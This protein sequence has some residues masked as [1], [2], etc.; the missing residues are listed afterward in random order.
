LRPCVDGMGPGEDGGRPPVLA[1]VKADRD[2]VGSGLRLVG[3][4]AWLAVAVCGCVHSLDEMT[5]RDFKFSQTF[6]RT[7]PIVVLRDSTDGDQR[8][9]AMRELKE[10]LANGGSQKDQDAVVEILT[11]SATKDKEALCRMA[12]IKA[13]A[14]FKDARAIGALIQADQGAERDF[15]RDMSTIIRQQ[16]L[17]ALGENRNA[18]AREWLIL[19]ARAGAKEES[20]VEKLQ[21]LDVRLT[22]IRSLGKYSQYES[23]ETL[24][25]LFETEKD[26]AVRDRAYQ[27]LQVATGKHLPADPKAWENLLHHSGQP[28]PAPQGTLAEDPAKNRA[29]LWWR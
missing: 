1:K 8:A 3:W 23:T 9:R 21:T 7:D 12:A 26:I 19:V 18:Q 4:L 16:A 2:T 22:A 28:S 5:A 15:N 17:A 10:P 6:T 27:S 11:T 14:K 20:E 25:H 24:L 13:L 29:T